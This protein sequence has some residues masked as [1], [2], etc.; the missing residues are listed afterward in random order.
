VYRFDAP[1]FFVNA[2][3]FRERVEQV[4]A[5]NPGEEDWLVLDFE[6]I[7]ALDATALD[8]LAELVERLA[9]LGVGVVAVARANDQVL[10]RLDRAALLEPAGALRVFPTINGAVR[11]YR[12][13]RG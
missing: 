8:V 6:G 5:E 7:G 13:R 11:A 12:Q 4:L 9:D 10:S 2:D 3:H 1:L